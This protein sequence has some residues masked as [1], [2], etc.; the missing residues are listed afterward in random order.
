MRRR[1]FLFKWVQKLGAGHKNQDRLNKK[2]EQGIPRV[3]ATFG[4]KEWIGKWHRHKKRL[5]EFVRWLKES[6]RLPGNPE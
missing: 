4:N 6:L 3:F 1:V 2:N 5:I